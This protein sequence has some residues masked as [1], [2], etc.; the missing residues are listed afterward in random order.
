MVLQL[1]KASPATQQ[2]DSSDKQDDE[3]A[4]KRLRFHRLEQTPEERNARPKPLLD[5]AEASLVGAMLCKH[6]DAT[7]GHV[8]Q[9]H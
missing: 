3:A 9:R 7:S 2:V 6:T 5:R 8:G 4:K 1:C